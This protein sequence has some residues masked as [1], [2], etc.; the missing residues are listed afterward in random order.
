[1]SDSKHLYDRVLDYCVAKTRANLDRLDSFPHTTRQGRW[2]TSEDG[3]WTAGHWIGIV[4][5]A[6]LRSG[7]ASLRDAAYRWAERLEPRKTDTTTHDMGFL[8]FPSFVRGYRIT[9]DPYFRDAALVAARS[10]ATRFHDNGGYIQAWDDAEDPVHKG[11]TIV[12][13]VMNLPLLLWAS[14]ESGDQRL[15]EIAQRVATTIASHHVRPD[16]STYHVVDF[17]PS[18]GAPIRYATHQGLHNESFWS[19]GQAWAIYGFSVVGRM[20]DRADLRDVAE[21]LADFFVRHLV[22]GQ[23]PPWDFAASGADEPR[24]SAA[25]AIAADGLLD[26]SAAAGD[27]A[28]RERRRREAR[29]LLNALIVTCVDL[30]AK[31]NEGLLLHA[32]ADRP[33]ES[34]VDESLVYGDHYFFEAI[35]RAVDPETVEPYL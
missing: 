26:L 21:I 30:A 12:D 29:D 32:T 35:Y 31:D 34:A 20:A 23:A 10:L 8:F 15:G 4:W 33:R 16:G 18:S 24:D 6:Y 11:R 5:L 25:G 2:R 17:N 27:H 19:R 3:R 13:T 1:M 28:G 22:P 14:D 9:R 7:D